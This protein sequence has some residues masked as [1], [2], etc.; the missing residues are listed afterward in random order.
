MEVNR[1]QN[2]KLEDLMRFIFKC[3]CIKRLVF[4]LQNIALA[5]LDKISL[6]FI[7]K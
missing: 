2:C 5:E 6:I 7:V 3:C 1:L 4:H